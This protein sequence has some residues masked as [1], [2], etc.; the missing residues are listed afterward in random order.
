MATATG[1][2][3][4]G[5]LKVP[6]DAPLTI[7]H[8]EGRIDGE[9]HQVFGGLAA[10]PARAPGTPLRVDLRYGGS[11]DFHSDDERVGELALILGLDSGHAPVRLP[12]GCAIGSAD[13]PVQLTLTGVSAPEP[14]RLP[15]MEDRRFAAPRTSHC[16]RLGP[17]LDRA[18]E[19]P[20]SP[21]DNRI[22]LQN[23]TRSIRPYTELP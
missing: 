20:A 22:R 19:L 17:L 9:F 3:K 21:G 10:A 11:F 5:R 12:R 15:A 6:L 7:T 14:G 13:A 18:L 8:A 2:L 23:E 1:S 16:G 4:V